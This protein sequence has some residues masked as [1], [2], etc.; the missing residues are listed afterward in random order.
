MKI[1]NAIL[2]FAVFTM[3]SFCFFSIAEAQK[4]KP[5]KPKPLVVEEQ[6]KIPIIEA[7]RFDKTEVY[8]SCPFLK[9]YR[10]VGCPIEEENVTLSILS[11]NVDDLDLE[12][13]YIVSGGSIEG[14]NGSAKW[15]LS[16]LPVGEYSLTVAIGKNG[17]LYSKPETKTVKL[18]PCECCLFPCSCP[19][20]SI[21][22]PSESPKHGDLIVISLSISG[23]EVDLPESKWNIV[24]GTIVF[25]QGTKTLFVKV[26]DDFSISK[27]HAT[28]E[29][30]GTNL[31]SAECL[32]SPTKSIEILKN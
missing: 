20:F 13:Y 8:K 16:G 22:L 9:R 23:G 12:Y 11:K 4:R 30:S 5:A 6:S 28:V 2:M 25:G 24:G 15:N 10:S 31:C 1:K 14:N 26:S 29:V 32:N 19:V 17:K 27:L 18:V 21:K 7:I 3:L